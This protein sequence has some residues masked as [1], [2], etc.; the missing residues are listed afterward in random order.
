MSILVLGIGNPIMSDDGVG[1]KVIQLLQ[2]LYIF[3]SEVILLDG[4]TMGIDLLPKLEGVERLI[5]VDAVDTGKTPGTLVLLSGN[6]IPLANGTKVSPHQ[7]ELKDLLTVAEL[8]GSL[9]A[10]IVLCGIQP[11]FTGLGTELSPAVSAQIGHLANEVLLQLSRWGI[12]QEMTPK[13]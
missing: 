5:L 10:E 3:P 2:S 12:R 8:L 11:A 6:E 13:K 9:P 7:I 1:A 4:G